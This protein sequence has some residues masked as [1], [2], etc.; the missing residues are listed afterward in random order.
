ME[1]K[2]IELATS[3]RA[4]QGQYL[5]F[6]LGREMF[7]INIVV[8]KEIT[9]VGRLTTV[10]RMPYFI[11]GVINLRGAVVPVIDLGARFDKPA[12]Q[13]S[14]RTCI[15]IIE[16]DIDG[17]DKQEVGV[18][19]DGVSAVTDIPAADIKPPP[20][21]GSHIRTDFI[22]G[23]GKVNDEF[24]IIL[25]VDRVLEMDEIAALASVSTEGKSHEML[26]PEAA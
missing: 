2:Q 4:E 13:I 9:E 15:I 12:I 22:S 16:V 19:V 11:R 6:M 18:M 7:A 10:P 20:S 24:V 8:I 23:V 25:N 17:D 5:V 26:L 1:A 14:R 21:F 3:E